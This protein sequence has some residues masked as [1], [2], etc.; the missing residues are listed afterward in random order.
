MKAFDGASDRRKVVLILSD[1][2][3]SGPL[4]GKRFI[5]Q[6][7]V[8]QRAIREDVMVYGIGLQSRG[9]RQ[10]RAPVGIGKGKISHSDSL[11]VTPAKAGVP[12]LF[13]EQEQAGFPL[14]RE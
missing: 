4:M 14:T 7:E 2:A 8:I 10:Y 13:G 9:P 11:F 5:S 3:D 1:G 12:L 6:G